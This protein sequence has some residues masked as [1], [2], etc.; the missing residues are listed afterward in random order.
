M[1]GKAIVCQLYQSVFAAVCKVLHTLG[2]VSTI[3]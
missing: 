2:V 3:P 1:P